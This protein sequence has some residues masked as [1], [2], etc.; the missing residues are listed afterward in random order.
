MEEMALVN[1]EKIR[2]AV[3]LTGAGVNDPDGRVVFPTRFK[4][5]QLGSAIDIEIRKGVFHGV[6]VTC[7]PGE[8][9]QIVLTL[10]QVRHAEFISNVRNIGSDTAFIALQI[11][12]ISPVL[13][14]KAVYDR[15]PSPLVSQGPGQIAS[16]EPQPSR[17]QNALAGKIL[18]THHT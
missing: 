18:E 11:E 9:E 2:S 13:R 6:Q 14:D 8:V 15:H 17:D 3:D 5:E 10:D 1:R 7:L 4:N 16:D 12:E